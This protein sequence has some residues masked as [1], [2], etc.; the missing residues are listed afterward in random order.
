MSA[1]TDTASA[2]SEFDAVQEIIANARVAM[3]SLTD[4]DQARV[5]EAV[6]AVAWAIY[7]PERARELA[8]L[9]VVD[10]NM[11]NVESKVIKNTRKTFGTLRDLL[12]AKTVG[13]IERNEALGMVKYAKPVGVVGAV[14]PSTNPA[15][16]PVNKAMMALKGRNAVIIA[17]SPAGFST[18]LKTVG[19]MREGLVKIGLPADLVQMLP[20]PVN[21]EMT[22][23]LMEQC[24]LVVVTGSQNNVR[25]A[26]SSGTP[27]IGVGGG[28]LCNAEE[29]QKIIDVLW[30]NG[31]L[32]RHVIAKDPDVLAEA[33]GLPESA[34]KAKFF[35]LEEVGVGKDFPL[36]D[37]KL[38]LVLT[39]YKAADFKAARS[40]L[41]QP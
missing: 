21:K 26:Y 35:M 15:A 9:A 33:A 32:N 10:T 2:I 30:V 8:E 34:K 16:T 23:Q 38:S 22:Q 17:A 40:R 7:Q 39:V 4:A 25:R 6:A 41:E 1:V 31:N 24:D 37:E 13:V 20:P 3:Q 14:T 11:G 18:T 12:R 5:D 36:S 29:R 19:Y 28:Y 27:A